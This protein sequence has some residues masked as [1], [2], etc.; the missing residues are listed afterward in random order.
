MRVLVDLIRIYWNCVVYQ[1]WEEA[2]VK[3]LS[4]HSKFN[5]FRIFLR[6]SRNVQKYPWTL[7][8]NCLMV[9]EEVGQ[10]RYQ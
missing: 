3:Y 6:T 10:K 5:S 9:V 2:Q 1:L 8:M 4:L 7:K